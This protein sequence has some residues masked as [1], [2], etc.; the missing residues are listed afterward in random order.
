VSRRILVFGNSG[1][2]KSTLATALC[3]EWALTHLDLDTLAWEA[4]SPPKRRD[5]A[6]SSKDILD[7]IGDAPGGWVIE[8]CYAD[9]LACVQQEAEEVLWLDLPAE[10]CI[11]NA[12]QR[13]WEPHKYP[14]KAAQDANLAMLIDWIR[15]YGHRQDE[16]S[17]SA[18]ERFFERFEGHKRRIT[19]RVR[20]DDLLRQSARTSR[21]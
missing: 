7:F 11:A 21:P 6:S 18:H 19:Q 20:V 2:G 3:R 10:D 8:G 13:P 17:R 16:F 14:S 15:D 5:L 1:S 9:L 4:A 12:R